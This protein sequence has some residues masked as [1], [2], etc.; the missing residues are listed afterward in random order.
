LQERVVW[1]KAT[2]LERVQPRTIF[3]IARFARFVSRANSIAPSAVVT[4]PNWLRIVLI[5][6]MP[7]P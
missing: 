4:F 5:R 7:L 3:Q 6:P 2:S 1:N